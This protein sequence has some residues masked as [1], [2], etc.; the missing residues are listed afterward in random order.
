MSWCIIVRV[1]LLQQILRCAIDHLQKP[2]NELDAVRHQLHVFLI[3]TGTFATLHTRWDRR[4]LG[5]H[6]IGTFDL[7]RLHRC[8]RDLC[9]A[10]ALH[11]VYGTSVFKKVTIAPTPARR[12]KIAAA[13]GEHAERL[14]F[15]FHSCKRPQDLERG[16]LTSRFPDGQPLEV[17][18]QELNELRILEAANFIDQG[19]SLKAYA[20]IASTWRSLA[21]QTNHIAVRARSVESKRQGEAQACR[22]RSFVAVLPFARAPQLGMRLCCLEK[23]VF[24]PVPVDFKRT[25]RWF[26]ALLG[27]ESLAP[28]PHVQVAFVLAGE[29]D[30]GM[31]PA[32]LAM[33]NMFA[34]CQCVGYDFESS[35]VPLEITA[36]VLQDGH[37]PAPEAPLTMYPRVSLAE[38]RSH[39][40]HAVSTLVHALQ[41]H[42]WI[43]VAVESEA[44]DVAQKSYEAMRQMVSTLSDEQKRTWRTKFDGD[45]YVGFA[46]D[47]GRE[48]IQ[49][50]GGMKD[51]SNFSWPESVLQ[52]HRDIL[53]LFDC[54]EAVAL[55][56]CDLLLQAFASKDAC[57]LEKLLGTQESAHVFGASVQRL[58][59]YFDRAKSKGFLWS[60]APHADMGLVTVAPPSTR[61]SLQL[62]SPRTGR[63]SYPED[64]LPPNEWVVFAGEAIAF[65]TGNA[66]QAPLHAVPPVM[67]PES[68]TGQ[69]GKS[70]KR[71]CSAPF[72]LRA[73][74]DALLSAPD[75]GN[76]LT[77]R[78]LM[79]KHSIGLRPWRLTSGGDW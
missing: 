23:Q 8:D 54:A 42:G 46:S 21:R 61:P 12:Q 17:S 48:W 32:A 74:P 76:T 7:L 43:A 78:E 13:F 67:P 53:A 29:A 24:L 47:P 16:S 57:S 62:W 68:T 49:L 26:L 22:K 39:T 28:K 45:R 56:I 5:E 77:C 31:P 14:A 50:R 2:D 75:G 72:F 19:N 58:F 15:L 20:V 6:L 18:A 30:F 65:L 3:R 40:P 34:S 27:A 1:R 64:G 60:S 9:V 25:R 44:A 73:A 55:V 70:G 71:R 66:V 59:A 38:L 10:G 36:V 37:L 33:L 69:S 51:L 63:L 41:E 4:Q 11:S 52:H 79:E 35:V